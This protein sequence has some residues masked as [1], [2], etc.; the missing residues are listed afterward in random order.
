L[1]FLTIIAKH[2]EI[3]LQLPEGWKS[4]VAKDGTVTLD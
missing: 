4:S 3:S 2:L 1:L